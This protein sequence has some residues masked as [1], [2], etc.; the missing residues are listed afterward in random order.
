MSHSIRYLKMYVKLAVCVLALALGL[1]VNLPVG[2]SGNPVPRPPQRVSADNC[3]ST[4][5]ASCAYSS[6][7]TLS[8]PSLAEGDPGRCGS[9]T[10]SA[11]V[12]IYDVQSDGVLGIPMAD[13]DVVR[14]NFGG[15]PG[16]GGYPGD[17]GTTVLAG[18]VDFHPNYQAVFWNLRSIKDGAQLHYLRGDGQTITYSVDWA[19][20]ISDPNY[21]W[22]ALVSAGDT[23][24]LVLITCDGTFN[25]DTQHYDQHF[26]VHA[27]KN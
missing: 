6:P 16:F 26:V 4:A 18:H 22:H 21:D 1:S 14:Q 27:V 13:C 2:A 10:I 19:N 25:P 15:A 24:T 12:S 9:A 20:A 3:Q 5:S 23:D 17:G 7:D 8:I 11:P